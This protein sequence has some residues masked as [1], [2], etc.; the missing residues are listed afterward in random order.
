[1]SAFLE[2]TAEGLQTT[3]AKST[4]DDML[5]VTATFLEPI[6]DIWKYEGDVSL[7]SFKNSSPFVT[8]AQSFVAQSND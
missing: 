1:V 5:E 4:I 3:Q 6:L 7:S 8:I 2:I